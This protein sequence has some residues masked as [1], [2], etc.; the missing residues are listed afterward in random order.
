MKTT[1]TIKTQTAPVEE[2]NTHTDLEKTMDSMM[3]G[4]SSYVKSIF[5]D[6]ANANPQNARVLRNF[7]LFE[8]IEQNLKQRTVLNQRLRHIGTGKSKES[9]NRC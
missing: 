3:E 9:C 4:A 7:I 6:L 2:N 5:K 8:R 1:T